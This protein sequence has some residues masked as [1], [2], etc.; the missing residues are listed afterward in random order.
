MFDEAKKAL[1]ALECAKKCAQSLQDDHKQIGATKTPY[2]R[3]KYEPKDKQE[4][5]KYKPITGDCY[6]CKKE[7]TLPSC[8]R[9]CKTRHFPFC[10]KLNDTDKRRT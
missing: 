1:L 8:C 10:S 5:D 3:S 9:T 4:D 7:H 2:A 6:V